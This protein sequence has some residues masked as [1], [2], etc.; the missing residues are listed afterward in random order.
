MRAFRFERLVAEIFKFSLAPTTS[1]ES[2]TLNVSIIEEAHKADDLKRSD[3]IDPML[4]STGGFSI[5]IGVSCTRMCDFK[6]GCDGDLPGLAIIVPVDEVIADRRAKYEQTHDAK[7]LQY[8]HSFAR[9]LKKN[10]RDN[11]EIR[12][13][14]FLEDMVEEGNFVSRERLLSCARGGDIIVPFD[15]LL[16]GLD[17]GRVSDRTISTIGNDRNDVLEWFAYPKTRYEEQIKLLI[18]DLKRPRKWKKIVDG[19][20]VEEEIE[21]FSRI[22]G[23]AGDATD[24]GDFPMEFL[25]S[26]SGLPVGQESLVKFTLQ[27]KH[28]MYSKW[29]AAL[30]RD[31][32][33]PM[34]FS[35]P[36]D[37]P[38]TATFEEQTTRLLR[39]YKGD[40][41]YLSVHHPDKPDARDDFPDSTA[42]MVTKAATGKI[43]E[44][45]F[46]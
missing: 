8:E 19:K 36:A 11:P 30:F 35:C 16:L 27:S 31:A 2:K 33:D 29:E 4:A 7:H 41:E 43:G 39:E 3:E 34:R 22:V 28:E 45:L 15:S 32:G 1:N 6:R 21:Y 12:R 40:G 14:F 9:E 13:N 10:G 38:L 42:L 25:Q 18:A 24:M 44:I 26:H 5:F 23:V 37:H 46:G 17:W 20:V